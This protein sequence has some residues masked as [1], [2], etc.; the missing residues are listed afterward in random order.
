M[1]TDK[2]KIFSEKIKVT[3]PEEI[4]KI[5]QAERERML[6]KCQ[7]IINH[8]I[9]VFINRQL[10]YN[11][12][13]QFFSD[14]G[15]CSIEHADFEGVERLALVL[16]SDIVST[17][18]NPEKVKLGHCDLIEEIMI[19][20]DK[21]IRFS[22]VARGEA[23]TILLRGTKQ[24]LD[25]AQ[26]SIH[27]ALCVISQVVSSESRIVLGAGCSEMLM[28]QSVEELAK[29]TSGKKS[30]AI[31]AFARALRQIPSIISDNG[32]YDS[33]ELITTLRSM[34][35]EGKKTMG[36]NMTNGTVGDV[37]EMKIFESLKVKRNFVRI[38]TEAAEMILRIDQIFRNA[39][40]KRDRDPRY[41]H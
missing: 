30:I 17:F 11:L 41:G 31:E 36:L 9:N 35:Y 26:R 24:M 5:E 37:M 13:E 7:K 22:G 29:K 28:A 3:S 20:E 4:A 27:V 33:S 32:G 38:A 15:V 39:P 8:G 40:R 23:C 34:H 10:I 6:E 25:E 19:G 16:G 2:I 14:H 1:D 21:C 12:P 18:D